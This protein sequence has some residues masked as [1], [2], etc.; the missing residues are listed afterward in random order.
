MKAVIRYDDAGKACP[1]LLCDQCGKPIERGGWATWPSYADGRRPVE[2]AVYHTHKDWQ[3]A[4]EQDRDSR[5]MWG[6]VDLD[7]HFWMLLMNAKIKPSKSRA[8]F[9]MGLKP[10]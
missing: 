7:A 6:T 5:A 4:F 3:R 1:L 10:Y 8:H 9:Y 2:S